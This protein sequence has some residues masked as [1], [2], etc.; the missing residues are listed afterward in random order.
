MVIARLMA[1]QRQTLFSHPWKPVS[2][3]NL[4]FYSAILSLMVLSWGVFQLFTLTNWHLDEMYLSLCTA[5]SPVTLK[6]LVYKVTSSYTHMT[7]RMLQKHILST[8]PG[9]L[10]VQ[11]V[12]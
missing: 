9:I 12:I 4:Y 1:S 6:W 5:D 2:V 7:E 10:F 11:P 8:S 3:L